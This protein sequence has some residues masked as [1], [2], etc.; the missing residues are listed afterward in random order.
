MDRLNIALVGCGDISGRHINAFQKV[1]ERARIVVCC[2]T[3]CERAQNAANRTGADPVKIASDFRSVLSDPDVDAVDL[4]LP[5]NL[6]AP[7]AI[8]AANA[9]KHVLCEKPLALSIEECDAMLAAA[10]AA[11]VVLAHGEPLRCAGIVARAAELISEGR[12]GKLVGL[13]ATTAYW[14]RAELNTE[15]RGRKSESGGGHLMVPSRN[16]AGGAKPR[17]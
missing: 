16:A 2:D 10:Q 6:H 8:A 7:M 12:I 14:Q 1:A 11:G 15:W 17:P 4:C 5:H 9:G 3:N 13:Q